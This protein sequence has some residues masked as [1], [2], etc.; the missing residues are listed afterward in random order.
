MLKKKRKPC[1]S[2]KS[3]FCCIQ[4]TV[5]GY[6]EMYLISAFIAAVWFDVWYKMDAAIVGSQRDFLNKKRKNTVLFIVN[7]FTVFAWLILM[8]ELVGKIAPKK[9]KYKK[10][11]AQERR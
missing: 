1:L 2:P 6:Y 10:K 3:L 11:H 7:K 4:A 5:I 8:S 9:K